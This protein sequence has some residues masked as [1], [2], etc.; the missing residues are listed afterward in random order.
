[1]V[2][3]D[4]FR[5]GVSVESK[6]RGVTCCIGGGMPDQGLIF[7]SDSRTNAGM[8]NIAKFCKMTVFERPDDRVIALLSPGNLAGGL[9]A[10]IRL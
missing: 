2:G 10:K 1:V 6:V 5:F 3:Y 8:D 9:Q 7:A 4:F